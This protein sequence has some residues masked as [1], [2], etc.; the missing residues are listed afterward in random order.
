MIQ[1]REMTPEDYASVVEVERR[2]GLVVRS[3]Q[4]WLRICVRNPYR[5]SGTPMG[6]ILEDSKRGVVGS[7]G[8][9]PLS[10]E[11]NGERVPAAAGYAWAVDPDFRHYSARLIRRW[12]RQGHTH[13]LMTSTASGRVGEILRALRFQPVPHADYDNVLYWV[14]NHR[15][16][17]ASA[18]RQLGLPGADWL[19]RPAAVAVRALHALRRP[20]SGAGPLAAVC[21]LDGFDARFDALWSELQRVP[22][23]LLAER[24]SGALA[25]HFGGDRLRAGTE[26]LALE[27]GSALTGYLVMFRRDH[28]EI[29][30][31]RYRVADLQVT[32]DAGPG[33]RALVTGALALARAKSIDL[34]E[35]IGFNARK[36]QALMALGPRRRKMPSW[37]F[38]YRTLSRELGSGLASPSAW[39]PSPFDGDAS[40]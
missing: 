37:L 7:F 19:S 29:G 31:T 15:G 1:V 14:T 12:L 3:R 33:C 20:R 22:D 38:Y 5:A 21:R 32:D 11:W 10:Y 24:S 28:E 13:L 2:N 4:D 17:A 6:W 35:L 40:L 34:V 16:F 26:I 9:L 27:H 23:R 25:W 39:D 30:L 36:R 8:N 18:L